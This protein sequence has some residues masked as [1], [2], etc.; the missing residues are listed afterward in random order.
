MELDKKGRI[1]SLLDK[2]GKELNV[3]DLV[4]YYL[5]YT[6]DSKPKLCIVAYD[7]H[8]NMSL[9]F[10]EK[11]RHVVKDE[12]YVEYVG[13]NKENESLINDDLKWASLI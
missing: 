3:G 6:D 1:T 2:N 8:G 11:H 9:Y 7:Y 13:N 12:R 5:H 4:N 10:E